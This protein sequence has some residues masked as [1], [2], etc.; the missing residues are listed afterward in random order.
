MSIR[1]RDLPEHVAAAIARHEAKGAIVK[2][3]SRTVVL[4]LP[5]PPTIN[6]YYGNRV[7]R[8]KAGKAIVMT[9]L[10]A[11]GR[12]F[13][14]VVAKAVGLYDVKLAGP[15]EM[16]VSLHPPTNARRD[17]DNI[18]KAMLDALQ[19]AGLYADDSQVKALHVYMGVKIEGGAANVTVKEQA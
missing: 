11:R 15:L 1:T 8:S 6:H 7:A 3:A 5:W 18:L 10:T 2:P 4:N 19:H 16:T 17:V 9:Y 12:Q 14:T 13:R